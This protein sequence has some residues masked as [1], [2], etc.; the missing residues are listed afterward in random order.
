MHTVFTRSLLRRGNGTVALKQ[1]APFLERGLP[2]RRYISLLGCCSHS[3][4]VCRSIGSR[5]ALP[6]IANVPKALPNRAATR[7]VP[8]EWRSAGTEEQASV[9]DLSLVSHATPL[10]L[11]WLFNRGQTSEQTEMFLREVETL[12]P[13]PSGPLPSGWSNAWREWVDLLSYYYYGPWYLRLSQAEMLFNIWYQIRGRTRPVLFSTEAPSSMFIF[14][15]DED[16]TSQVEV[17]ANYYLYHDGFGLFYFK[18]VH[19][20]T[21]LS[22]TLQTLPSLHAALKTD[23]GRQSL[24]HALVSIAPQ[25]EGEEV[26]KRIHRNDPSVIPVVAELVGYTPVHTESWEETAGFEP[27]T[28]ED[29]FVNDLPDTNDLPALHE[30]AMQRLNSLRWQFQ[31]LHVRLSVLGLELDPALRGRIPPGQSRYRTLIEIAPKEAAEWME[32]SK[33]FAAMKSPE[34]TS[35]QLRKMMMPLFLKSRPIFRKL[36]Q[37]DEA[38][39]ERGLALREVPSE[40]KEKFIDETLRPRM[41]ATCQGLMSLQLEFKSFHSDLMS[42]TRTGRLDLVEIGKMIG[43]TRPK[44]YDV[45]GWTRKKRQ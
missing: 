17:I 30:D 44:V 40:E 38:A 2:A 24:R 16:E 6:V 26:F 18:D 39:Q 11:L 1:H 7:P 23:S 42:M 28:G 19:D 13:S 3:P 12:W 29:A 21:T 8:V 4:T 14:T 10:R 31:A 37:A 22:N 9:W 20:F 41:Q 15:A 45:F 5:P 32:W 27:L 43:R 25:P 34:G 33:R 35:R 36:A